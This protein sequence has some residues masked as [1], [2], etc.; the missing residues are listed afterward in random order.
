MVV[1]LT[2]GVG[3]VPFKQILYWNNITYAV[4]VADGNFCSGQQQ[5]ERQQ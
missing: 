5:R 2:I 3:R 1:Y 4:C